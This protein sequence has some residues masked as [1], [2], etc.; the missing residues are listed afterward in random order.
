M[1]LAEVRSHGRKADHCNPGSQESQEDGRGRAVRWVGVWR[2]VRWVGG[3]EGCEVGGWYG[4]L[5]GGWVV[6]MKKMVK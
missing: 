5:L 6:L 2:A 3:M 4:G 1:F